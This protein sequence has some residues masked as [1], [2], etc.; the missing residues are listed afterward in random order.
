MSKYFIFI[1]L[2]EIVNTPIF[3][4]R[5]LIDFAGEYLKPIPKKIRFMEFSFIHSLM[6]IGIRQ[7]LNMI[8]LYPFFDIIWNKN[9]ITKMM[10]VKF[11]QEG[12]KGRGLEWFRH[13]NKRICVFVE[14][15]WRSSAW[16]ALSLGL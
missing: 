4:I 6:V 3:V 5:F 14:W 7:R 2:N 10:L 9:S 12:N 8:S 16:N 1:T 15:A 13:C 11:L